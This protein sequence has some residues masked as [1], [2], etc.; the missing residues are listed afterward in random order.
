MPDAGYAN[1]TSTPLLRPKI[2]YCYRHHRCCYLPENGRHKRNLCMAF[3]H[4]D[5]I[6]H[7][8]ACDSH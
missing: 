6:S 4:N 8:G 3:R 7:L 1:F 5:V 2:G